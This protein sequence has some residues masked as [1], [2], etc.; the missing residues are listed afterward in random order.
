M[1]STEAALEPLLCKNQCSA[2]GASEA[3]PRF[4]P[5]AA[6]YNGMRSLPLRCMKTLQPPPAT[7][8][9]ISNYGSAFNNR[10]SAPLGV[11]AQHRRP[12]RVPPPLRGLLGIIQSVCKHANK[13]NRLSFCQRASCYAAIARATAPI[14]PV[15]DAGLFAPDYICPLNFYRL[16]FSFLLFLSLHLM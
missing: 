7:S 3:C 15:R 9:F 12:L 11:H 4:T 5:G 10:A 6:A 14:Q 8:F 1:E 2:W 13:A 16:L